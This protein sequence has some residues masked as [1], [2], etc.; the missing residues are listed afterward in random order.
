MFSRRKFVQL[1]GAACGSAVLPSSSSPYAVGA[2]AED[3]LQWVDPHIGT[4]G[5]GHCFPGATVPFGAV[6]LSPDT[7]N[8]EWDWCSGYHISDTSIM[9]FSHTHLSGTGCGD[10]LDFLVMPGIGPVKLHPG[11]R[12]NPG[13]G[14]RSR[15]SHEDEVAEPG[16]YSVFLQDPAIHVELTAT[17]RTGLHRY[18]FPASDSAWLIVD[19]S[20]S[21]LRNGSSSV[22]S[23]ELTQ[24]SVGTLAGGHV[25]CA[26]TWKRH[27]YF[28]LQVSKTPLRIDLYSDDRSVSPERLRDG[29]LLGG[30][31]KAVLHFETKA[32]ESILVRTGISGVSAE[33]A[34]RN[35]RAEQPDWNFEQARA[36]AQGMWR[37]QLSRIRAEFS[38]PNQKR[39]FYTALYHMSLGPTLYDDVDG[40][41]RGMDAHTHMLP[42]GAHNYT[43]FSLWDTFRAAHP[44]YTIFQTDRVPDFVNTLIRMG[45]Q[46]PEGIP[47]WP[48][49]G[50]ETG[51]MTG[52]HSATVMSEAIGKSIPGIDVQAAYKLMIE[53]ALNENFRGMGYYR[54][55]GYLPADRESESVSECLEYCYNDWAVARVA[56]TLGQNEVARFL[57]ERSKNYRHC[58]NPATRFI[59]PK[60]F[61]GSWAK[62][63]TPT[64]LG[65]TARWHDYTESNAWQTSF[66]V[67][68]DPAGLIALYGGRDAFVKRLD[69]LFTVSSAQPPDAP[70]DIAGL[71]GQYAHGNE[72]SHHIAYLYVYAGAPCRTQQRVR[73]LMETMYHAAP[74][75]IAGNEDVGQMSAWFVLSALGFYA[76]DPAGATYILGSPLIERAVLD[77]GKGKRLEIR[78][79]RSHPGHI[80]V[81]AFTL[82]GVPQQR[83]WFH[84]AEI[85][86]GGS[87]LLEMG[88]EP[89]LTFGSAPEHVP[90]SLKL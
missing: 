65:H 7:Y 40:Q 77:V 78:A 32:H 89:N 8:D 37:E 67:Q 45:Q 15:F 63:F 59:E 5:H 12:S 36:S 33:G 43:C 61:D 21:Y 46:S 4:G 55:L 50:I 14:Y 28:T 85:A 79:K 86:N 27:C 58:F 82:H 83:A 90:P 66:G 60:L 71:V 6:Q 80:Y 53:R 47:V 75:G 34:F 44:A 1:A 25:T 64:E 69:L 49:Q 56:N 17:E 84:H 9:G 54:Q 22:F 35:L 10:L 18:T 62:P 20:H 68:H 74:D 2:E 70:L 52:Y 31:L 88:P 19:L 26:W 16:F 11:S 73:M 23:A 29:K 81:Q 38:D 48:L 42:S 72:P 87:I 13:E 3:P 24:P 39:I 57:V 30:N 51:G 41:Y 76:V